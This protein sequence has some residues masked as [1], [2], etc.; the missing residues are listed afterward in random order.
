MRKIAYLTAGEAVTACQM[1]RLASPL[2]VLSARGL[3]EIRTASI[4]ESMQEAQQC[5][6]AATWADLVVVQRMCTWDFVRTVVGRK[7]DST[8]VVYDLD[9]DLFAL[10][11]DHVLFSRAATGKDAMLRLAKRADA[12]TVTCPALAE[13]M[14]VYNPRVRE[15][16]NYL[17]ETLWQNDVR[18]ERRDGD[19]LTVAYAG[20]FTHQ[21]DLRFV[22]PLIERLRAKYPSRLRFAFFGCAPKDAAPADDLT[23]DVGGY[24]YPEYAKRMQHAGY[25]IAIAPLDD[26]PFNRVKSNIKYLEYARCRIAGV[27][28]RLDPYVT[29]V[30]EGE[31]GLL[32]SSDPEEWFAKI[33]MLIDDA[34]LRRRIADAAYD[35]VEKKFLLAPHI[36]QWLSVYDEASAFVHNGRC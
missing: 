14:R 19:L 17:D 15:L 20:S 28:A 11:A 30:R 35:D 24:A 31:T 12:L 8:A 7:L 32:A 3:A 5:L 18:R 16:P 23:Y 25:D 13:R 21:A 29:C 1:L 27:Y 4:G 36:E 6:A 34:S 9:D 22:M 10:P 2:R 33:S 26:T